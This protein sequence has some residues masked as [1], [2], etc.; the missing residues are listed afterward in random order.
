[1]AYP[2]LENN[3]KFF[4][5]VVY[6]SAADAVRNFKEYLRKGIWEDAWNFVKLIPFL[7]SAITAGEAIYGC[8]QASQAGKPCDVAGLIFAIGAAVLETAVVWARPVMLA[9][10]P[11]AP[12]FNKSKAWLTSA[13]KFARTYGR[14]VA[15]DIG[16]MA[17]ASREYLE[18]LLAQGVKGATALAEKTKEVFGGVMSKLKQCI[19]QCTKGA[20]NVYWK[21]KNA[22]KNSLEN[23]SAKLDKIL[24]RAQQVG[25][26]VTCALAP[27][28]EYLAGNASQAAIDS[29][30]GFSIGF[31]AWKFLGIDNEGSTLDTARSPGARTQAKPK[32]PG[33]ACS[34]KTFGKFAG[35][36]YKQKYLSDFDDDELEIMS[37]HHM[38][39]KGA[40]DPIK[41]TGEDLQGNTVDTCDEARK[42]L[43]GKGGFRSTEEPC[44]GALLPDTAF[45]T[46]NGID[47][48]NAKDKAAKKQVRDRLTSKLKTKYPNVIDHRRMHTQG[49]F[50]YMFTQ[51]SSWVEDDDFKKIDP[52]NKGKARDY[53]CSKMSGI[54]GDMLEGKNFF[55]DFDKF[56]S[57]YP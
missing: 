40:K 47:K 34:Y 46:D 12:V 2:L 50:Q 5:H 9:L 45:L 53:I 24:D 4:G 10:R 54:Y 6:G 55:K 39:P 26:S 36:H 56:F 35:K 38:G 3:E 25:I 51:I 21:L 33:D 29:A 49:Y 13:V 52:A 57:F 44:N 19:A 18:R 37:P 7:G 30:L 22:F 42:I 28:V 48:S 1:M 27:Q 14:P 16:M 43:L 32:A 15:E 17:K 23:A 31:I 11:L 8:V 20:D 41:C